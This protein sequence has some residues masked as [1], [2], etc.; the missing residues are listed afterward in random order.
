MAEQESIRNKIIVGVISGA[1][2][3][4]LA[5]L[6]RR[7]WPAVWRWFA[8]IFSFI[9]SWLWT[10]HAI[11][12]WLLIILC[13][14]GFLALLRLIGAMRRPAEADFRAYNEDRFFGLVW[15]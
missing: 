12:G 5:Y 10:A 3:A 7:W 9:W 4:L 1:I 13:F 14:T 2:V 15:R 8:G 11:L 6:G